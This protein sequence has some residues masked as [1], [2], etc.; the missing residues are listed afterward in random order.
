MT[1]LRCM[2][3]NELKRRQKV[4]ENIF[5]FSFLFSFETFDAIPFDAI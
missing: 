4:N 5:V 3:K 2:A 1:D